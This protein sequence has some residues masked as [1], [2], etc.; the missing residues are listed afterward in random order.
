MGDE[1]EGNADVADMAK[2]KGGDVS[3]DDIADDL[4]FGG[5]VAKGEEEQLQ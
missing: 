5:G 1:Y 3:D 2:D 4:D